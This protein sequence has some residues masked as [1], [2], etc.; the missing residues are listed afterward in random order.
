[1]SFLLFKEC[2][3]GGS[4]RVSVHATT[5]PA[6]RPRSVENVVDGC[7]TADGMRVCPFGY[8]QLCRTID[9]MQRRKVRAAGRIEE[10]VRCNRLT[11]MLTLTAGSFFTTREAALDAWSGY[12]AHKKYGRW[13]TKRGGYVAI[14]EP[15]KSGHFHLH[16]A[17]CRLPSNYL[18]L[19]KETWT[20]FLETL[21]CV[22]P[23][24]ESGRWRVHI[25]APPKGASSES[26]GRYLAKYLG[27]GLWVATKDR[28]FRASTNLL[29]ATRRIY[30]I[31]ASMDVVAT[32]LG[33]MNVVEHAGRVIA[34]TGRITREQWQ[35]H[36]FGPGH[37]EWSHAAP[38]PPLCG[39]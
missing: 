16:V 12:V 17:C 3:D 2:K 37:A 24:T 38:P 29:R 19:L 20:R 10:L 35:L 18:V 15:H 5:P 36:D 21:G 39:C 25:A 9:R 34:W 33:L 26:L 6:Q 22:R 31:E 28:L 32:V 7:L 27:K 11:Y 13:F 23:E 4:L 1:M 8:I 14:A 30:R